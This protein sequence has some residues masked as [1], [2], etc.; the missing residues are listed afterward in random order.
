M[1]NSSIDKISSILIA[2]IGLYF[3]IRFKIVGKRAIEQ[4]KKLNQIFPFRQSEKNFD[5]P[6]IAITQF[7]FLFIGAL[8]FL[9]GLTRLIK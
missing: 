5:Q 3:A 2:L 8:F 9:V 7:M 6:S 4:R 1:E